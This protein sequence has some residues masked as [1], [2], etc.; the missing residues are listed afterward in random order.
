MEKNSNGSE[1]SSESGSNALRGRFWEE[2]WTYVKTV[3]DI[4]RE[5]VLILDSALC[6]SGRTAGYG[7]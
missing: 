5:P 2:S 4:V 6:V 1:N 7:K 3:V